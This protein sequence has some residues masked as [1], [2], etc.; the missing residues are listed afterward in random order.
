MDYRLGSTLGSGSATTQANAV[1]FTMNNDIEISENGGEAHRHPFVQGL[2]LTEICKGSLD[3]SFVPRLLSTSRTL[4]NV[5]IQLFLGDGATGANCMT[6]GP[7][8]WMYDVRE[9]VWRAPLW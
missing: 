6:T 4:D 2:P 9:R 8:G 5:S 1:P 3:L 7:G